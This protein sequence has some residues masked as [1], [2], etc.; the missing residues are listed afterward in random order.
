[1]ET[2]KLRN[3]IIN[4]FQL[5]IKDDTKLDFLNGVFDSINITDSD[6]LISEKHYKIIEE[7]R[8]KKI[9]GKTRGKTWDT[10][11]LE[12]KQKHGF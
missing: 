7:R 10:V 2:L 11:K 4:Q 3:K 6:S 12:L 5:F 1:M 9:L 8:Q